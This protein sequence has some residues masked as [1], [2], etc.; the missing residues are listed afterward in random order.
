MRLK[1]VSHKLPLEANSHPSNR[2]VRL[3][4]PPAIHQINEKNHWSE[5][6]VTRKLHKCDLIETCYH[7]LF[8]DFGHGSG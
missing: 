8:L 5:C 7:F 2:K 6:T 4:E 1:Y 3:L